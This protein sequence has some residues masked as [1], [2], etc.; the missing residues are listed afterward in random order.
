MKLQARNEHI[1]CEEKIV[2][3]CPKSVKNA[4]C[5]SYLISQSIYIYLIIIILIYLA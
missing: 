2:V 3:D 1:E 4:T 5:P